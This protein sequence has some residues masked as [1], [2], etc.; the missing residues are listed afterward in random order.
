MDP[1]STVPDPNSAEDFVH[2]D[3]SMADSLSESIVN[4]EVPRDDDDYDGVVSTSAAAEDSD[5]RKVLPE[6]LSRSVVVLTCDSTAE[7]GVC[8]VHLVGTAHVSVVM[9]V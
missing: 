5:L 7:G 3:N 1:Q 9:I 6:E 2:V 4:V 8:D